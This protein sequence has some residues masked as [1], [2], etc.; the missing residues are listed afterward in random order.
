MPTRI[1][2]LLIG[3]MEPVAATTGIATMKLEIGSFKKDLCSRRSGRKIALAENIKF[4]NAD[5]L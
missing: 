4:G 5:R 2:I 1:V 3:A